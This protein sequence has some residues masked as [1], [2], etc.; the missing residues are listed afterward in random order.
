M[1]TY[2]LA[3][4]FTVDEITIK[5]DLQELRSTGIDI[6]SEKNRGVRLSQALS[7]NKLRTLIQQYAVLNLADN[8]VEKSTNLLVSRLG[9][10]SLANIVTLQ[11]CLER[12]YS[13]RIDYEKESE[14]LEFGK[15]IEPI[16]IF[17]SDNTWRVLAGSDGKI[18]Q[19]LI[20]KILEA[21][22]TERKFKPVDRTEIEDLFRYSWR[23]WLGAGRIKVKLKFTKK[24][25]E[26]IRLKPLMEIE[27]TVTESDG[28]VIYE[29]V[30][31]SLDEIASWIIS[32]GEGVK[33]LEP[34]ELK[35]KVINL[36][37]GTLNNYQ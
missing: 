36:A 19:F 6:H 9:E 25:A 16:L 35:E 2:D 10:K 24:W 31:N 30:V 17:Q 4:L 32:R 15:I 23:S 21:R 27:S 22:E 11:I 29:T 37:K 7:E 33:V 18:K 34:G 3:E 1:R 5:R 28:S 14:E 20:N 12:N 8:F 26:R 13:A